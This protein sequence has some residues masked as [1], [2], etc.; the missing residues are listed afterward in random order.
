[1]KSLSA[2]YAGL[3]VAAL[4]QAGCGT[5]DSVNS[6]FD[7][8]SALTFVALNEPVVV[9]RAVTRVSVAGRDYIYVGP[10][11]MNQMG[12]RNRYLWLGMAST[13]DRALAGQD[14]PQ[15]TQLVLT[16]DGL[17]MVFTLSRWESDGGTLPYPVTAPVY[18]SYVTR[19][20]L[21]QIN[22]IASARSVTVQLVT[23]DSRTVSYQPWHGEWMGWSDFVA[24]N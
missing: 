14:R 1:M 23:E 12:R 3:A 21:D 22:R 19:A 9:A 20:S 6:W 18:Q 13:V 2:K 7:E 24:A 15:A 17:P 16:V 10:L 4:L 8:D 11:E 5:T